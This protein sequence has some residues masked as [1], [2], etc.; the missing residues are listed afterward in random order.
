LT[1]QGLY[2]A[3]DILYGRALAGSK[4]LLGSEH[5]VTLRTMANLANVCNA[6]GQYNKAKTLHRRAP[7]GS[8]KFLG[9]EHPDY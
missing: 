2:D 4:K 3:A 6:Q 8:K 7:A 5:P 9:L 1:S